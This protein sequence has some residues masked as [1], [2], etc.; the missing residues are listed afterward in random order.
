MKKNKK[1]PQLTPLEK[2][3]KILEEK[4][5]QELLDKLKAPTEEGKLV[6]MIFTNTKN[7]VDMKLNQI[8]E[9]QAV[10]IM[11]ELVRHLESKI[12]IEE[13]RK[14]LIRESEKMMQ[15]MAV[16]K[17]EERSKMGRK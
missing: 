16:Q 10:A 17:Q 5:Q 13:V 1:R 15:T 4:Q 12:M 3:K 14:Q 11:R 7:Q 6:I 8:G 2:K 9:S